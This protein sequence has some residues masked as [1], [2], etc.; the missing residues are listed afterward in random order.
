MNLRIARNEVF[1]H[2]LFNRLTLWSI[3]ISIRHDIFLLLFVALRPLGIFLLLF[4]FFAL[5]PFNMVLFLLLFLFLLSHVLVHASVVVNWFAD[6]VVAG[7]RD[8]TSLGLEDLR[9]RGA[10]EVER[11]RCVREV[12]WLLC[13]HH[14][15]CLGASKAS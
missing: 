9:A 6:F 14:D 13:H 2:T 7:S 8:V 5:F 3:A 11:M 4:L 1:P 10:G 15:V 12:L